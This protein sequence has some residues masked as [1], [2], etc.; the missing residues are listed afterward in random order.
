MRAADGEALRL[1]NIFGISQAL[2]SPY[3]GVLA[4][5]PRHSRSAAFAIHQSPK[6]EVSLVEWAERYGER[7]LLPF[8]IETVHLPLGQRLC[9]TR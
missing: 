8:R 7:L 4:N 3:T 2:S 5:S 6:P 9:G 1:F